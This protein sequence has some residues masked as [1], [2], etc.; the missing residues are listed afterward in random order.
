MGRTLGRPRVGVWVPADRGAL[1]PRKRS[2]SSARSEWLPRGRAGERWP[3]FIAVLRMRWSITGGYAPEESKGGWREPAGPTCCPTDPTRPASFSRS[4]WPHAHRRCTPTPSGSPHK[5][6]GDRGQ[7]RAPHRSACRVPLLGPP[8]NISVPSHALR[9]SP[10]TSQASRRRLFMKDDVMNRLE[11]CC[12][13][14]R[15]TPRAG[16]PACRAAPTAAS[17]SGCR[18]PGSPG[19]GTN[20]EAAHRGRLVRVLRVG[21][22]K[23]A[24]PT[25]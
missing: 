13:P 6:E 5:R 21:D 2:F 18:G 1:Q 23:F 8:H 3:R 17:R 22:G 15:P 24:A 10:T 11:K 25:T 4:K 16:A 20:P 7:G 12:T 19:A 14:R 9:L